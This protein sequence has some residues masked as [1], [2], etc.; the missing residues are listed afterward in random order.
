MKTYPAR[1]TRLTA[2]RSAGRIVRRAYR[3]PQ[4][5]I[6]DALER[7][8]RE[9]YAMR[10]GVLENLSSIGSVTEHDDRVTRS[11][12]D[13]QLKRSS[14]VKMPGLVRFDA[15]KSGKIT[16]FKEVVNAR[17][18][19]AWSRKTTWEMRRLDALR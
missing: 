10:N 11:A 8:G 6:V 3:A 17:G 13:M 18:E 15:V 4:Q 9:P 7:A 5:A 14:R 12:H 2:P 16:S 19:I 1:M